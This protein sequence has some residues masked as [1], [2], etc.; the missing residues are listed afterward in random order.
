MRDE[1]SHAGDRSL[2][3]SSVHITDNFQ[4]ISHLGRAHLKIRGS[5]EVFGKVLQKASIARFQA[6]ISFGGLN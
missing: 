3:Q 2:L 5:S 6:L 4:E 1:T